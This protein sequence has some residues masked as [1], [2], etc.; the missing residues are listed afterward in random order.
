MVT[1]HRLLTLHLLL[2]PLW[3]RSANGQQPPR[4]LSFTI[5]MSHA[6]FADSLRGAPGHCEPLR[7][8]LSVCTHYLS[9]FG[10]EKMVFVAATVHDSS[11]LVLGLRILVPPL[12]SIRLAR[13]LT[14]LRAQWGPRQTAAPSP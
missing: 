1:G 14:D 6:A 9:E 7:P 5:G 10:P 12:D 2:L 3:V 4:Y 13:W 11:T 8:P